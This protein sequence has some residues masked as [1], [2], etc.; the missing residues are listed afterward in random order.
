MEEQTTPETFTTPMDTPPPAFALNPE[1]QVARIAQALTPVTAPSSLPAAEP[2]ATENQPAEAVS[3]GDASPE[4]S[5]DTPAGPA[6]PDDAPGEPL[7]SGDH[8]PPASY[9]QESGPGEP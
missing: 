2:P 4:A 6:G 7:G 9:A 5:P 3:H 8:V 1:A